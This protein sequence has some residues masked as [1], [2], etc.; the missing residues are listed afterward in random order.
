MTEFYKKSNPLVNF[1]TEVEQSFEST[2]NE[3]WSTHSL[4]G[5]ESVLK[6]MAN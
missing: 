1:K 2:F 4:Y 3:E 5:W 6:R